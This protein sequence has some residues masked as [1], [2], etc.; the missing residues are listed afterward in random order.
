MNTEKEKVSARSVQEVLKEIRIRVEADKKN[1]GL[2]PW[3]FE[4][5]RREVLGDIDAMIG[6]VNRSAQVNAVQES[7]LLGTMSTANWWDN[8]KNWVEL[9]TMFNSFSA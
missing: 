6:M 1:N 4:S 2:L 5:R 3:A 9:L 7:W 8:N